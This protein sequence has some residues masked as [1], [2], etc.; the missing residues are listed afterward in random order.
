MLLKLKPP[1]VDLSIALPCETIIMLELF[2]AIAAC[3]IV[4]VKVVGAP[5][6]SQEEPL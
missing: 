2:S 6:E 4:P 1:L 3:P 5:I